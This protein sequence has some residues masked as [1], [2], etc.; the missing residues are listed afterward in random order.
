MFSLYAVKILNTDT[1]ALTENNKQIL[2]TN[3]RTAQGYA[4]YR[5]QQTHNSSVRYDP[6]ASARSYAYSESFVFNWADTDTTNPKKPQQFG[7]M[8]TSFTTHN[9]DSFLDFTS[10]NLDR[11]KASVALTSSALPKLSI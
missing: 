6:L 10:R 7:K 9:L 8:K 1:V 3:D 4:Q 2:Y 5:S 11:C